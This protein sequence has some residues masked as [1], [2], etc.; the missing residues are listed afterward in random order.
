[1]KKVILLALV[2]FGL[3][4]FCYADATWGMGA[5]DGFLTARV[6]WNKT[7]SSEFGISP[8]YDNYPGNAT[9]NS[10]TI[11]LD[12]SPLNYALYSDEH[13]RINTG[14]KFIPWIT[15]TRNPAGH[16]NQTMI[17]T[18]DLYLLAPEIDFK[19]IGGLHFIA[20]SAL[21]LQWAY[22]ARGKLTSFT[23]SPILPSLFSTLGIVYYFE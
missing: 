10:A 13:V 5:N 19:A 11:Y 20:T 2:V 9:P 17:H 8:S 12:I 4:G 3:A 1:M 21:D 22:N 15:Y 23:V 18:Y 6:N 7:F 14:I 16:L